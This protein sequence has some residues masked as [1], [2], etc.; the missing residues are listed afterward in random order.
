[1][2]RLIP[3]EVLFFFVSATNIRIFNLGGYIMQ[4]TE[5]TLN[6]LE[7]D[8]FQLEVFITNLNRTKRVLH[9]VKNIL[10]TVQSMTGNA[11]ELD[12]RTACDI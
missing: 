2:S 4:K 8:V 10:E 7:A 5:V 1:V 9:D 12:T 3:G 11:G 6:D